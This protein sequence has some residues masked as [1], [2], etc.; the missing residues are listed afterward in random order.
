MSFGRD[1]LAY[2]RRPDN[3]FH[4]A[5]MRTFVYTS[6]SV[7]VPAEVAVPR[8]PEDDELEEYDGPSEP[9]R[10]PPYTRRDGVYYARVYSSQDLAVRHRPRGAYKLY[11]YRFSA[12]AWW[13]GAG[14]V[15]DLE[16]GRP[17]VDRAG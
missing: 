14:T 13:H 7:P 10:Y 6:W 15:L 11:A 3:I 16:F 17:V 9:P 1:D 8:T 4:L 2:P 12:V 5:L